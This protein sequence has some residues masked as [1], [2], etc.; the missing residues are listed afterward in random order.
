MWKREGKPSSSFLFFWENLV[1]NHYNRKSPVIIKVQCLHD[2]A[3]A[4]FIIE[5]IPNRGKNMSFRYNQ[6]GN[7]T[8]PPC[9][10]T[11]TKHLRELEIKSF[12]IPRTCLTAV[13]SSPVSITTRISILMPKERQDTPSPPHPHPNERR[14]WTFLSEEG[15]IVNRG[16]RGDNTSIEIYLCTFFWVVRVMA[17]FIIGT[18]KILVSIRS[19]SR[20]GV[21]CC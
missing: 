19:V 10:Q 7:T 21:D 12:I 16:K 20:I 14:G 6:N 13:F 9:A 5:S 2:L 11:K 18:N 17:E 4:C 1:L 15:R 3:E 8:E